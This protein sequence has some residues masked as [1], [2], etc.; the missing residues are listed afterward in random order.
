M[1]NK[2]LS[3]KAIFENISGI[4]LQFSYSG[5]RTMRTF[6]TMWVLMLVGGN[7]S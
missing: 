7:N 2:F 4:E 3:L 6:T 1:F 5:D